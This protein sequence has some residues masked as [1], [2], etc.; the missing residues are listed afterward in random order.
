MSFNTKG[1]GVALITPFTNENK[2]DF[3]ALKKLVNHVVDGGVETL[4]VLGTTGEPAV[5]SHD[6]KLAVIQTVKEANQGRAQ[7]VLGIGGN[8]TAEVVRQLELLPLDGF[9][10]ILSVAP[11][12]NRP[13]QEGLYQHFS[14]LAHA[15]PLPVIIYNVPGRTGVNISAATTLRLARDCKKIVATKE[16]SGNLDQ[17]MAIIREKPDGF[18]LISGDDNLTFPLVM[19][20]ASGVISVS[21]NSFPAIMSQMVREALAGNCTKARELHYQLYHI[22]NLL[23][24]D[25]SPAGVKTALNQ[26]GICQ[27]QLR[28]PLVPVNTETERAIRKHT[29]LIRRN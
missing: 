18:D 8:N 17:C 15:S 28:L 3:E 22:T 12:Y 7:M 24:A 9:Q 11:Y 21:A 4:A 25:G 5:L 16:A 10:A 27:N 1:T 13:N 14:T 26:L 23:F 19:L 29:D 6:E 20:G 2:I